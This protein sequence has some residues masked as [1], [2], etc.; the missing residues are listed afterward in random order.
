M[1]EVPPWLA[2]FAAGGTLARL[3]DHTLL[4]PEA[5]AADIL[6]LADQAA[7]CHFGA[8]CVN[9]EWVSLAVERLAGQAVRTATV[10]GFPL[11]ASGTA[12]KVAETRIAVSSGADEIDMVMSLGWALAGDWGQ[13]RTEIAEVVAAAEGRLVKVILESAALSAAEIERG[14]E[15][16]VAAGAGM[17]KT[18]TGFHPAG[19]ATLD[20]VRLIRR[21]VG[22]RA[23]VKASGGVR[24]AEEAR[25]MLLAGADRL[26]TSSAVGW[27][28]ALDRRLDEYLAGEDL[29]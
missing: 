25:Q 2:P 27:G 9:G 13:V 28:A 24:T 17:V 23:G 7:A 12:A 26:G 29:G 10:V 8:V 3:V 6:R 14:A 19:G 5:T 1:S 20:A 11:G 22:G 16:A 4:R 15:V 18:S 21:A